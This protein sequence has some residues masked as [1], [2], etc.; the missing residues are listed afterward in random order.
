MS[1]DEHVRVWVRRC[2][3]C[4][5]DDLRAAHGSPAMIDDRP[6]WC[7]ACRAVDWTAAC[8]TFPGGSVPHPCPI[9]GG[10]Q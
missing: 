5:T 6:W 10:R 9:V 4:A 1:A 2:T 8:L 3:W 7:P